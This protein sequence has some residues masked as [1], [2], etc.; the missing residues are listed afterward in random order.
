M[1]APLPVSLRLLYLVADIHLAIA[2]R[3]TEAFFRT[4]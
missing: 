1:N 2:D 3:I 4:N